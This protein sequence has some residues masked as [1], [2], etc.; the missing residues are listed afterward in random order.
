[1]SDDARAAS[2]RAAACSRERSRHARAVLDEFFYPVVKAARYKLDAKCPISQVR[3]MYYEHETHKEPVKYSKHYWRSLYSGKVFKSEY[4]VDKHMERRHGDKIPPEADVCLADHCDLL[5]CDRHHS[6]LKNERKK[7]I[8][9]DEEFLVEIQGKCRQVLSDCFPE[10]ISPTHDRAKKLSVYF[11]KYYCDQ[12][13]CHG[14]D[15][16]FELL[17][18]H[19]D[20]TSVGY[21]VAMVFV[22]LI[23]GL[24][25]ASV[26]SWTSGRRVSL[27][28]KRARRRAHATWV[29]RVPQSIVK[30]LNLRKRKSH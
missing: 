28:V 15:G 14:V 20:T 3:D 29:D 7:H 16:V 12:L 23:V 26:Y 18:S 8:W 1:M 24:Y 19:H 13:T 2:G 4:Y 27:D 11:N 21:Y 10:D 30:R 22:F 25:Y 5:Q 6:Y 9:C 17:G